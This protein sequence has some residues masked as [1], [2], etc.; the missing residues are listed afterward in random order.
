M[1]ISTS[2]GFH[3]Q[4]VN[5]L[6]SRQ[7]KLHYLGYFVMQMAQFVKKGGEIE[8][9]FKSKIENIPHIGRPVTF[10][11]NCFTVLRISSTFDITLLLT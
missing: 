11:T 9:Q 2:Q 8:L 10:R 1:T 3:L 4:T 5:L 6:A 7:Y